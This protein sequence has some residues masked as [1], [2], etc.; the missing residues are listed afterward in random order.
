MEGKELHMLL[1]LASKKGLLPICL[2]HEM[3]VSAEMTYFESVI[4][5]LSSITMFISS[6]LFLAQVF[7]RR[8]EARI[9]ESSAR[10]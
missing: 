8:E 3:V 2:S 9:R 6:L 1:Y 4:K 10:L 7:E 5:K